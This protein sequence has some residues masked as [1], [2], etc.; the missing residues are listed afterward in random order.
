M[1]SI[2]RKLLEEAGFEVFTA[3]SGE[4]ALSVI[5]ESGISVT[6]TDIKMPGIDGI[7]LLDRIK[8]IDESA[9]VIIMTAFSSVDSAIAALRKGAYDYVT[10]PLSTKIL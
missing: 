5:I 3:S 7:E 1:R 10:K 6:L 9:L 4:A 2:I 8:S